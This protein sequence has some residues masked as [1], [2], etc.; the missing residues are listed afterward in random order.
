MTVWKN[1]SE[2]FYI[3]VSLFL[4]AYICISA[5]LK[6]SVLSIGLIFISLAFVNRPEHLLPSVLISSL[7][8][9]FFVAFPGM[10]VSRI[11]VLV[12]IIFSFIQSIRQTRKYSGMHI[13]SLF[14]ASVF[15]FFSSRLS[16]TG[17][18]KPAITMILNLV[19]LFFMMYARLDNYE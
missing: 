6:I 7:L 17:E 12:Y 4:I 15:C 13:L 9:D 3:K 16:L 1:R 14:L 18:I 19:M 8:G 11:L 10:G 5:V 2:K